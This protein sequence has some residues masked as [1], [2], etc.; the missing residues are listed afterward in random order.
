MGYWYP[1][2]LISYCGAGNDVFQLEQ[3]LSCHRAHNVMPGC[4]V[5]LF[6]VCVFGVVGILHQYR[7]MRILFRIREE[8]EEERPRLRDND[9]VMRVMLMRAMC[10]RARLSHSNINPET[11]LRT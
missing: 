8:Q 9:I 2:L 6:G 10:M 4:F 5:C 7:M 11:H 3:R 1:I